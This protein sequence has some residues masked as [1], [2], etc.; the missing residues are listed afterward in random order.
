MTTPQDTI[1][2]TLHTPNT[3][4]HLDT[5]EVWRHKFRLTTADLYTNQP[6]A[7]IWLVESLPRHFLLA[8]DW[9]RPLQASFTTHALHVVIKHHLSVAVPLPF[10]SPRT[11]YA[12]QFLHFT[13]PRLLSSFLRLALHLLER[14]EVCGA[15]GI[16]SKL[17][18]LN[19]CIWRTLC[20]NLLRHEKA[21]E[22]IQNQLKDFCR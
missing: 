3:S 17:I 1:F 9:L 5:P 13:S 2:S 16:L 12:I 20:R 7:A 4:G 14:K 18:S 15:L 19:G 6:N 10:L 21:E 11:K 22:W 8:P